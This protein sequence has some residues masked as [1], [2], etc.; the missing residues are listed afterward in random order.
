MAG[1]YVRRLLPLLDVM[2]I[3]FGLMLI[4]L[5]SADQS[6]PVSSATQNATS[7]APVIES[8]L[9]KVVKNLFA[10]TPILFL[11]VTED[12]AVRQFI[13]D[14]T[15][16]GVSLGTVGGFDKNAYD[17]L[18]KQLGNGK[19][20][21]LT[22]VLYQRGVGSRKFTPSMQKSLINE[23]GVGTSLLARMPEERKG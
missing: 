15:K 12:N 20:E 3:L 5:I 7:S 18:V 14:E 23:L 10:G 21:V 13:M 17:T 22:I 19:A 2:T 4:L 8:N 16:P 11:E 6:P 9:E 1:D